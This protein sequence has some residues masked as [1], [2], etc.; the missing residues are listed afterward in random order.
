MPVSTQDVTALR[1]AIS[2]AKALA[3]QEAENRKV[4]PRILS[5]KDLQGEY[6]AARLLM[7]TLGGNLRALTA[8]DLAAFRQNARA[9]GKRF[10]GGITPRK[11]IDLSLTIDR[12]RARQQIHTALPVA[13]RGIKDGAGKVD[14]LEVRF[15]TNA[16]G[17][18][19]AARHH[20][21]VEFMGYAEA[22]NSGA[23]T[24]AKA[25]ALLRKG[26]VRFDCGCGRHTYWYRYV[27]TIGGFN[28]GRAENGYPKIRNPGLVGVACKH[29][30]RVMALIEGESLAQAF[31]VR[32]IEKGR[33]NEDGSGRTRLSQKEAERQAARQAA[34]PTSGRET[35]DRDFDRAARALRKQSR[36][37][38]PTPKRVAGG[39]RRI[40][41]TKKIVQVTGNEEARQKLIELAKQLG[42]SPEQAAAMLLGK[43]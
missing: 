10:K 36:S 24:A 25:A 29:V 26:S 23:L 21:T 11:I 22:I 15:M 8:D 3:K 38:R 35:G 32:A 12:Q 39:S 18:H 20:V 28:A 9:L 34:R 31:L 40:D 17:L 27:A 6:D 7:T 43:T 42:L 30:L 41:Q 2:E 19:G 1:G 13:S 33:Q 16:S 14:R 5:A 37:I 4:A